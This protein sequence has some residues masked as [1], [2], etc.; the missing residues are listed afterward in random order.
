MKPFYVYK[1]IDPRDNKT[2]Y[3]GKGIGKR[4]SQHLCPYNLRMQHPL[5]DRI[6]E[7]LSE[8]LKPVFKKIGKNLN[9]NDAFNLEREVIEE[10]GLE[11]LTNKCNGGGGCF[12]NKH[13]KET[14]RK[15]SK[16][17]RGRIVSKETREKLRKVLTGKKHSK[18]TRIKMGK[19]QKKRFKNPENHPHFGRKLSEETKRKI[20][21][22]HKGKK[23][24]KETRKKMSEAQIKRY[25]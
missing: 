21:E 14:K 13:S 1:I 6:N 5:Y 7:I 17:R 20:S 9:E 19:S 8:D 2:F 12:G 3:V 15:M 16:S 18:E 22:A 11:N 24:S 23:V 4:I 25:S 10:I